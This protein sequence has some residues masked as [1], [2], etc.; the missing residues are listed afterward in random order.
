MNLSRGFGTNA[1]TFFMRQD[2]ITFL[3]KR[4]ASHPF[5]AST[6]ELGIGLETWLN[7]LSLSRNKLYM[8]VKILIKGV[9]SLGSTLFKVVF[10]LSSSSAFGAEVEDMLVRQAAYA[11]LVC[12]LIVWLSFLLRRRRSAPCLLSCLI[13]KAENQCK[14]AKTTITRWQLARATLGYVAYHCQQG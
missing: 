14:K 6:N 4:R 3:S 13:K 8:L 12:L 7:K 1:A 9:C 2:K 5:E 10:G 11:Y